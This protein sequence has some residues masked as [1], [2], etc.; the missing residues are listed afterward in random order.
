MEDTVRR[1]IGGWELVE[2]TVGRG[3]GVW[4][5]MEDTVGMLG[6]LYICYPCTICLFL[7]LME[8]I[9]LPLRLAICVLFVYFFGV[10]SVVSVKLWQG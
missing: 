2:N 5:L 1:G 9:G 7:A 4:K 10:R 3:I 6:I 8:D